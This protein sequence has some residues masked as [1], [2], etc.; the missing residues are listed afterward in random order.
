MNS[1][2]TSDGEKS[3]DAERKVRSLIAEKFKLDTGAMVI[4]RAHRIGKRDPKGERQ[5]PIVAKFLNFK[6]RELVWSRRKELKRAAPGVYLNEDFSEA[7]RQKRKE[8]LPKLREAWDRG[9]IAYFKF[10]HL[11]V[12]PPRVRGGGLIRNTSAVPSP[13]TSTPK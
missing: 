11:V 7:V 12:H 6:D 5:R 3:A 4:E 13:V 2:D 8:L 9:D 1:C 10:D